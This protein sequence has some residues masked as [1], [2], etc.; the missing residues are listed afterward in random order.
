V[1]PR[2]SLYWFVATAAIGIYFPY[3]TLYLKQNVGLSGFEVGLVYAT[4]PLVGAFAQPLWSQL[5]DRQGTRTGVLAL[6]T[7]GTGL[8][9]MGLS[10]GTGL[11]SML[12]ASAFLAVFVTSLLPMSL[13][14][15]MAALGR[16]ERFKFGS[17]RAWG[18]AGYL[19]TVVATPPALHFAQRA[20]GVQ[21]GAPGVREPGLGGLFV[22]AGVVMCC[23]ALIAS[24]LPADGELAIRAKPGEL[25]ALLRRGPYL[26]VLL[27]N[28]GSF[29]FLHAPMVLFPIYLDSRGGDMNT[30]SRMWVMM[31]LFEIPLVMKAGALVQRIGP[32]WTLAGAT[33]AG[34]LRWTLCALCP[35]VGPVYLVQLLH[36]VVVAGMLV[37]T[38]MLIEAL[39]PRQLRASGQSGLTLFGSSIAGTLS[40]MLGGWLCDVA[41]IDAVYWVGGLGGLAL[42]LTGPWLLPTEAEAEGEQEGEAV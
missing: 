30:V 3:F 7:L 38:P 15:S 20:F 4:L 39:V 8:G 13:A 9:Y 40:S 33:A 12:I 35:T 5:A 26:R 21:S 11:T 32:R 27:F 16:R 42:A 28:F 19:L 2:L 10:Q 29:F 36:A 31:L 37:A 34:G 22:V 23:A 6:V 18:T 17:V 24:R 41:G 14:V 1:L 25:R